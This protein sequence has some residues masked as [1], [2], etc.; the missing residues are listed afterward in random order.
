MTTPEETTTPRLGCA[1]ASNLARLP[2]RIR[3]AAK[4]RILEACNKDFVEG[5][6]NDLNDAGTEA[7]EA[8]YRAIADDATGWLCM[9]GLKDGGELVVYITSDDYA[10]TYAKFTMKELVKEVLSNMD[11]ACDRDHAM[12][13]AEK[14]Q[15]AARMLIQAFEPK[16]RQP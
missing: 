10:F 6:L 4:E 15:E 13:M 11:D 2:E 16:P 14:L 12:E 3:V 9:G 1:V 5:V 7:W 8:L